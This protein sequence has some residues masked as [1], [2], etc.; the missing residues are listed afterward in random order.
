MFRIFKKVKK[1]PPGAVVQR[2]DKF[3]FDEAAICSE[4]ERLA[5]NFTLP[6][7]G[8]L[9]SKIAKA[10]DDFGHAFVKRLRGSFFN[11]AKMAVDISDSATR[12]SWVTHDIKEMAESSSGIVGAVQLLSTSFVQLNGQ[13]D[14]SVKKAVQVEGEA[15]T[16]VL[17]MQS[18]NVAMQ[19]ISSRM[20]AIDTH[21]GVLDH[22]VKQ[23]AE[24]AAIIESISAQ[25]NL[26]AL[27]ATIEAARAGEAGKGFGVV[28]S[29]VKMLSN[30]TTDATAEIYKRLT[31]LRNE[32]DTIKLETQ[33]STA[34]V[35]DGEVTVS[36]AIESIVSIGERISSVRG[37]AQALAG[38]IGQQRQAAGEITERVTKIAANTEKVSDEVVAALAMLATAEQRAKNVLESYADLPIPGY[39]LVRYS[40]D[41]SIWKRQL[42]S[43]F[44]GLVPLPNAFPLPELMSSTDISAES[45]QI[46]I[47]A[48]G[49]KNAALSVYAGDFIQ[50]LRAKDICNATQHY[51]AIEKEIEAL[52]SLI[53][54]LQ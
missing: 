50:A 6:A 52:Q 9:P 17:R 24:M 34:A 4:L 12:V 40:A 25:T 27:N 36:T 18:V 43:I 35:S 39:G 21:V 45:K 11:A 30:H 47:D 14:E 46:T 2:I 49:E 10:F 16:C 54:K 1:A 13:S 7:S 31:V 33:E 26:L 42:A 44:L 37:S 8:S 51:L 29:E 22:A 19:H 20:A 28:A 48:F 23:I 3:A 38:V 53:G 5:R 15:A 41:L 32:M